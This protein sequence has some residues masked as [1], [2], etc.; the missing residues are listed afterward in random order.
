MVSGVGANVDTKLILSWQ[1][2]YAITVKVLIIVL[3]NNDNNSFP[4][5]W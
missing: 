5:D 4:C 2:N 3:N 1:G